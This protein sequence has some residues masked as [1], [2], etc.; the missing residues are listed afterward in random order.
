MIFLYF[1][2]IPPK[3][4]ACICDIGENMMTGG[5]T[6]CFDIW[7]LRGIRDYLGLVYFCQGRGEV[8]SPAN[9]EH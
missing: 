8:P 3:S 1:L 7:S 5:E 6:A 2:L 9:D 4:T